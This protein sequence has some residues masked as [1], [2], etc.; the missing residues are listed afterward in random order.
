MSHSPEGWEQELERLLPVFLDGHPSADNRRRLNQLLRRF[1]AARQTYIAAMALHARL[2]TRHAARTNNAAAKVRIQP[3]KGAAA[4]STLNSVA[5]V[6]DLIRRP[7]PFSLSIAAISMSLA[8]LVMAFLTAPIYRA[9]L[10]DEQQAKQTEPELR[11][12]ARLTSLRDAVWQE[13]AVANFAGAHL[14]VGRSLELKSG[15]AEITYDTGACLVLQ[16]PCEFVVS[17]DNVGRLRTGELYAYVPKSAVGFTIKTPQIDVVDLGTEFAVAVDEAGSAY[18]EVSTGHVEVRKVAVEPGVASQMQIKAG[19]AIRVAGTGGPITAL[20]ATKKFVNLSNIARDFRRERV[21]VLLTNA[22]FDQHTWDS[23]HNE[24]PNGWTSYP[25]LSVGRSAGNY[26]FSGNNTPGLVSIAAHLQ[27]QGNNWYQQDMME[28]SKGPMDAATFGEFR[29]VFDYGYRR[30][31]VTSGDI[32]LRISLVLTPSGK[33][34]VGKELKLADLGLGE[35]RLTRTEVILDYD[36]ER[37]EL[38]GQRVALRFTH[39]G[40]T[41]GPPGSQGYYATAILDNIRV[42]AMESATKPAAAD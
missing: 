17:L 37:A 7:T 18:V 20:P 4:S 32:K 36:N 23:L 15:F 14:A 3:A 22:N 29:V 26:G 12:V 34:L 16:G 5:Q 13:G 11:F 8:L 1:P 30:D 25:P 33:E 42:A 19:E 27:D 10:Q 9:F 38:A 41:K 31:T 40:T 39:A 2:H 35:N 21:S 28:T 6:I 24:W